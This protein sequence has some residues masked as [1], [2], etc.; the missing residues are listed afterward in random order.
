MNTVT[1]WVDLE[2]HRQML[3]LDERDITVGFPYSMWDLSPGPQRIETLWQLAEDYVAKVEERMGRD[4][5]PGSV[6]VMEGE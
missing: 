2:S 1:T 6:L 3:K 5:A 4:V